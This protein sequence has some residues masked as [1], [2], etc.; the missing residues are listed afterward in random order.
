LLLLYNKVKINKY[1]KKKIE[2]KRI[3]SLQGKFLVV[4]VVVVS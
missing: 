4:V 2:V 1:L 3:S